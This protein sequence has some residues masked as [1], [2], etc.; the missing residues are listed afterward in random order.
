LRLLIPCETPGTGTLPV[1]PT[2][3]APR[4]HH[5][6]E[7]HL[8]DSGSHPKLLRVDRQIH[9]IP[10]PTYRLCTGFD[11]PVRAVLYSSGSCA[12]GRYSPT[13]ISR[14]GIP[15][16]RRWPERISS[17]RPRMAALQLDGYPLLGRGCARV[18][19]NA[20]LQV[21]NI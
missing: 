14:A 8:G 1:S 16:S 3:Q 5:K 20:Q 12:A 6:C 18:L 4:R 9:V 10:D 13:R 11:N 17:R 21:Y 19:C 15:A 7:G 2:T